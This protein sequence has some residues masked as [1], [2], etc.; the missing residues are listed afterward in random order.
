MRLRVWKGNHDPLLS[1]LI[2]NAWRNDELLILCPPRLPDLSF[3]R[4]LPAGELSFH[5]EA[6]AGAGDMRPPDG[7][8][9]E[10][11]PSRPVLGLFTSGTLSGSPRLV[12]YSRR[13]VEASIDGVLAFFDT[14]RIDSVFCYPQPYHTFGLVLGYLL[15]Q[16]RGHRL[17]VAPGPYSRASHASWQRE[18]GR[19]TVTLGT[20]THFHDLLGAVR[21]SGRLPRPSYSCIIGGAP[22]PMRLWHD[23]RD[24]LG[25]EA[26]SV[27]YGCTEAS[28]GLTHLAPGVAPMQD[29]EIGVPLQ[30]VEFHPLPGTGVEFAGDNACLAIVEQERLTFPSR[31]VIPDLVEQRADGRYVFRGRLGLTV[32][33]GGV[34][35]S[36][37]EFESSLRSALG[38]E[39]VC[40]GVPDSR[41]GEDVGILAARQAAV[42]AQLSFE[43]VRRFFEETFQIALSPRHFR[44]APEIPMNPG[45]KKDRA[46]AAEVF[47]DLAHGP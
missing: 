4:H 25:I 26:P 33:R 40:I 19:G 47:A 12:L 3:V 28:P 21:A 41:L 37:E 45:G 36:L 34:K 1:A 20:P 9:W 39:A 27:G 46:R 38:V 5:G 2:A 42:S 18:A 13:N 8:G 35:Y 14:G 23:L 11:Q 17:L 16:L 24:V 31:I 22:V 10:G 30:G 6:V 44:V 7:S 43:S 32:N 15:A 29:G